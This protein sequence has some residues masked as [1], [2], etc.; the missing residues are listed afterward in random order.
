MPGHLLSIIQNLYAR[1]E[2]VLVDGLKR[3]KVAPV[4]G[5][6]QGCPLSP[7]LFSLYINDIGSVTEECAGAVTGTTEVQVSHMLYADDLCLVSNDPVQL[8]RMLDKLGFYAYRKELIVNEKKSEVVH[9]VWSDVQ[10]PVLKYRGSELAVADSF[11]Y[12]GMTFTRSGNMAVAAEQVVPA[13]HGG[14]V[15]VRRFVREHGLVDRLHTLLWLTKAYII[16]ASM[17]GSQIWGTGYMKE[18]AEMDCPLQTGHLCFL[19]RV[20]GVKHTA[21]NWS[22]LRECGHEPLQFYWFRA[23]VR[24][25]NSLLQSNS[26]LMRKVWRADLNM[27]AHPRAKKCWTAQVVA[28]FEGLQGRDRYRQ[29]ICTGTA[30]NVKEFAVDLR[31]R[32]CKVWSDLSDADPREHRHKRI[33]YHRWFATPLILPLKSE[34]GPYRIPRYLNLDLGRHVQRNIARFRLRAHTMGVER[35]CLQDNDP[36]LCDKCDLQDVQDEKHA[37]FLC[38][39]L[40]ICA[41]RAKYDHLF[42]GA[43]SQTIVSLGANAGF[44]YSEISNSD[45]LRFLEQDSN[46]MYAFLSDIMDVFCGA[47]RDQQAEQSNYLAEGQN[48]M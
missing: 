45:I 28:A 5:V 18:G 42:L 48:P 39:C 26:A 35:A 15:R 7:L 10:V 22:V 25:Y 9:F 43:S 14:C 29:A 47:G 17:Y 24:F 27:S 6:K 11:R 3:A 19:K 4:R 20:L 36:G 34:T 46:Q 41:L 32:L 33:S 2:Y 23:A 38:N 12:L 8:Q 1:D 31:A 37:L 21:C 13:F 30:I 40:Q 16:P 44:F